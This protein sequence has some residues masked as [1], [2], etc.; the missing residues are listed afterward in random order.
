MAVDFTSN[1]HNPGTHWIIRSLLDTDQ[2]KPAM[3]QMIWLNRD[4]RDV[5][6]EF[7]VINRT[8]S[9]NLGQ[10]LDFNQVRGELD[11]VAGLRWSANDIDVLRSQ[12]S[13]PA[14]RVFRDDFLE[15]LPT[16]RLSSYTLSQDMH[17]D[18]VLGFPGKWSNTTMWEIYALPV[19]NELRNRKGLS[20]MDTAEQNILF[21]RANIKLCSKLERLS[22]IPGLRVADFGTR[23]RFSQEWQDHVVAT[24]K[25]MLGS[26]F[27]GTSN[28]FLAMKHGIEPIGTNAHELPM[29]MTAMAAAGNL[30][31]LGMAAAQYR[32]L[33]LWQ[34]LYGNARGI[35]LPDTYGSSQFLDN[36][37]DWVFEWPGMRQ[38]SKSP[39]LAA[40]E[41]M[42]ALQARGIDPRTRTIVFSDGLDVDDIIGL[43]AMF[44]GEIQPGYTVDDFHS[45]QDFLDTSKWLHKPRIGVAFGWGTLL[46]NDFQGCHPRG[47]EVFSTLS[48]VCKVTRAAGR[49]AVKLSDNYIKATGSVE[50]IE[51]Y[52]KE[53]GI[54]GVENSPVLV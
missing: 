30:G 21:S 10:S 6:T 35:M 18:I 26:S 25:R 2:Y 37:P 16:M 12:T 32:V 33:E 38:D 36:A 9:V 28:I 4:L 51:Y 22:G 50:E 29:V 11:H 42:Q 47:L 39:V 40:T 53:F 49:A 48:L 44:A 15:W 45:S 3:L 27:T 41:Y 7:T 52:R 14:G 20:D 34:N 8:R 31:S 43:H 23:R 46:T 17:G 1:A 54:K 13:G 5:D 19:L 24:C